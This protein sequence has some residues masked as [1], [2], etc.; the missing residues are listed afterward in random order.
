[1]NEVVDMTGELFVSLRFAGE[2]SVGPGHGARAI[3]TR[4]SLRAMWPPS[5]WTAA[6]SPTSARPRE[7]ARR[8]A[9]RRAS[10]TGRRSAET[11]G[12][13]ALTLGGSIAAAGISRRQ[14][15]S[16]IVETSSRG[17]RLG[18]TT[19]LGAADRAA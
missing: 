11:H 18:L 1:M 8:A 12:S 2:V 3:R 9:I 19:I 13:Q 17:H 15:G 6:R 5:S 10:T 7:N 14:L 4:A 16:D